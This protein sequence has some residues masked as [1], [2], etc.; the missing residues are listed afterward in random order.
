MTLVEFLRARLDEDERLALLAA[1]PIGDHWQADGAMVFAKHPT[2]AIVDYAGQAAGHIARHDPARVLAE[3]EAKRRIVDLHAREHECVGSD[4]GRTAN[5]AGEWPCQ[6][7]RLHGLP[8]A[9]HP[10][11]DESWRS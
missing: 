8:Y 4:G 10:D 9:D 7:L 11:Y 2:D 1:G 5:D 3:V 6:T